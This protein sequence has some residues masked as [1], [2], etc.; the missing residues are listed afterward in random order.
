MLPSN[1]TIGGH[2]LKWLLFPWLLYFTCAEYG[3]HA[4]ISA[5]SPGIPTV[6]YN[7]AGT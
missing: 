7:S 5:Q 1:I 3:Q 4:V 6:L 2:Q